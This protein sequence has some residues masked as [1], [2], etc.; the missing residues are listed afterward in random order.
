MSFAKK[1]IL[2]SGAGS[3]IGAATAL[4]FAELGARLCLTGRNKDKLIAVAKQCSKDP[5]RTFVVTGDLTKEDDVKNIV[6]STIA[7]YGR[8]DVLVNNA[9]ILE[10]GG[11]ETTNLQQFDRLFNL[12]V[13]ATYQLTTLAVPHLIQT[14]GNIINVSSVAGLRGFPNF[15]PYCMSKATV[16]HFT[17][18]AALDLGKKQVRVNSVNPGVIKTDLYNNSGMSKEEIEKFFKYFE[19]KNP[20]ERLGDVKDVVNAITFLASDDASHLTGI[21]LPIDGGLQLMCSL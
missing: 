2:I 1:V 14:K 6:K 12:N 3:G 13:R 16:D 18:C 10:I 4:R 7:H 20:L 21:T 15:L 17:R 19:E 8:L 11:I 5:Q 9:G